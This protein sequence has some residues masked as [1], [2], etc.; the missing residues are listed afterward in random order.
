ML[1]VVNED[2][3]TESGISLI[4][5][6]V[7]EGARRMLAAAL[8]AEV[9]Q[10]I[11]ELAG[12]HDERGRRLVVR[13]GRHRPRS[14]TTAAGPVEVA[15]PRVNDKRV[16]AGTGERER[17]SSKILAPWCRK[18]PKVSE[19]LPLLYLHGLSSG[20]FVPALEQFLGGTA[21]LSPATVTRLTKQWTA[22]HAVFQRRDLA[23]TDYVYV[24]ADGIHPKI[25]L[26]QTHSCLLVLM[27]VR[28]D[29]TK[30]LIAIAEGLRESTESWADLLRD[31]RRRGMRDPVLVTGDGAMGLWRAL[32]EVFPAAR[33]QRCWVHKTRNVMNALPKSAQPGA[34]KAL[35]EIYNAEDRTHAQKA[36]TAFEKTYGAKWPKAVKKITGEVDELLAF[37]DF[38][39][40]HWIHLRTTN[41]IESTFSTVKLRT[42]VTR[43]AGSPTAA[44]AMVFKLVESAQAR[45]RAVTAP[46]LVALVRAGNRFEN[47]HLVDQDE[48][49]AA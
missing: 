16:D 6:I 32:A 7:R 28:V 40:E 33:H 11:A 25:R 47:G 22:D 8:E 13:N 21:G 19:V 17:F 4:D 45:W 23:E 18:S 37:Y 34:R 42:K 2:G 44:L 46:H 39:A 1:S 3:T 9:E 15:A 31:C 20:D 49:L 12:Q 24:W 29:G 38:P 10:Y 48:T 30:E 35:Q 5:E 43:G 41:P 26:S 14:V 36:V 27:G